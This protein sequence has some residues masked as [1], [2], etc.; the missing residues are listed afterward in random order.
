MNAREQADALLR[1]LGN[2]LGLPLVPDADGA[3]GLRID[4][5]L[6][7]TLRLHEPQAALLVYAQVGTLPAVQPETVL[8]RL[9]AANHVWEGSQG[10]TWSL[11]GE[12]LTLSR[13]WPLQDLDAAGLAEGLARFAEVALAEQTRLSAPGASSP[14][15]AAALPP[16][17][18][19]A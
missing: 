19:A 17:V 11:L 16:G 10:A 13:L 18:W 3:C 9:L 1:A 5:R 15:G 14:A 2:A 6:E 4:E 7:L 12:Q 8:R